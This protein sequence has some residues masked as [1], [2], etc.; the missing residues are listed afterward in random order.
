MSAIPLVALLRGKIRP[1]GAR[2]TPSGIDKKPVTE[3]L[4]LGSLGLRGDEQGDSR[5]HGGAEKALHHYAFDH[6][7]AWQDDIGSAAALE[8]PGA[9]GE[10]I[11]TFDLTE[12]DVAI[13]DVFSLGEAIVEVSQGR[14]PCWKLNLRFGV[15]DMAQRVQSSGRTGWYYRVLQ[16]G[17]VS[18]EDRLIRIHRHSPQWTVKRIWKVFYV[19]TLDREELSALSELPRLAESWRLHARRRLDTGSVEDWTSRL[20][21]R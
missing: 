16:P 14:Q 21:G 9:F 10:N 5:H 12:A 7:A 18:P 6:Y 15:A 2:L 11:A 20:T 4:L 17:M 19:R 3:P 1:L 8:G 13:G